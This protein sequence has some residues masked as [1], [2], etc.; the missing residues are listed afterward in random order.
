M[1]RSRTQVLYH[2]FLPDSV[3]VHETG[4]IV[5]SHEIRGEQLFADFNKSALLSEIDSYLMAW[6]SE[7]RL[8]LPLPSTVDSSEF[9]IITPEIVRWEIWPLVFECSR[10]NCLRIYKFRNIREV[11]QNPRCRYC[12]GRLRQLRYYSAHACGSIKDMYIPRCSVHGYDHIY[13]EDTGSFRSSVFRCRACGGSVIRR[14]AQS[15]CGCGEFLDSTGRSIMRAYTLR[16]TRTYYSHSI[17]LINLQSSLFNQLQSHPR[18]GEICIGSYLGFIDNIA[19]ILAEAGYSDTKTARLSRG[20]WEQKEKMYKSMGLTDGEIAVLKK[21]LGPREE[22][23]AY[24]ED[25]DHSIIEL[26]KSRRFIERILLFEPG[27]IKMITLNTAEISARKLGQMEVAD[28]IVLAKKRST[29]MGIDEISVTWNFPIATAAFGYTRTVKERGEGRIRGFARRDLYNG[30]TPIFAVSTETEAII[31]TIS[32]NKILKWLAERGTYNNALPGNSS[33]ARLEILRIFAHRNENTILAAEIIT[34][35]HSMSH[36]MLRALEDAQSGFAESSLAEWVVPE[37]LTFSIYAN[38]L[39]SYTLGALWTL[40]NNNALQW[41]DASREIA[42]RCEND[43]LCYQRE[44][45]ACERCL[46]LTFGCEMFN[47]A[48]DRKFLTEFWSMI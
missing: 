35:I 6:T 45:R 39:K 9:M 40:I 15:P 12:N 17:S 38:S 34:L 11:I 31:L 37:A 8:G 16:D 25:L 28:N 30:K 20:E 24:I 41:L 33:D 1:Q 21:S 27:Q 2:P 5:R 19:D 26:G 3:F 48:L 18:R 22:D 46:F 44:P 29:Q 36:C 13:F 32:A 14:T 23:L 4:I 7:N 43:P 42:W 10:E 47:E